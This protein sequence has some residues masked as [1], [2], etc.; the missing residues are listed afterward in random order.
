MLSQVVFFD[1]LQSR[2][3]DVEIITRAQ[4]GAGIWSLEVEAHFVAAHPDYAPLGGFHVDDN[5]ELCALD[6]RREAVKILRLAVE[7]A[8]YGVERHALVFLQSR[9]RPRG[10]NHQGCDEEKRPRKF[11]DREHVHLKF[12]QRNASNHSI[13][14]EPRRLRRGFSWASVLE[15]ENGFQRLEAEPT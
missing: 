8:Q 5:G 14:A 3:V 6:I 15:R 13:A 1:A 2:I 4:N 7:V 9:K 10:R 11:T 12:Q